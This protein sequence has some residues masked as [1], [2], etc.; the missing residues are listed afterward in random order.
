MKTALVG[1]TGLVGSNLLQFYN[2]DCL[3]NSK[4]FEDAK[5]KTFDTLFFC[6][7]P[8]VKW[9]AN[10]Y[11]QQDNDTI[12]NIKSILDTIKVTSF[13][14]ISTVDVYN[15]VDN[16]HDEDLDVDYHSNHTYGKNRFLFE[17]YVKLTF[18]NYHIVRL[19]ALF[20][21]GLKKNIIFDLINNNNIGDIPVNSAFQWY[22]LDWLKRDIDLIIKNNIKVCNL[23]I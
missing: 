9:H 17:E 3:Y 8:A 2:F 20:G 4:N 10:K 5:Y 22:W 16:Q 1:Y 23:F 13:V 7:V 14:L 6:G 12:E 15:E 18:D 21:K 11:P 19:P